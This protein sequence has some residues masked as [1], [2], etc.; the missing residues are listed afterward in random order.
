[1]NIK[2]VESL[3]QIVQ[4]LPQ[5]ERQI[6][7]EKLFFDTHQVTT[8]DIMNLTNKSQSFDFLYDE[9]DIYTL[10]DGKAI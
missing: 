3:V 4:S 2:L 10:E 1:M 9:P 6:F 7:E 5:E 8:Q